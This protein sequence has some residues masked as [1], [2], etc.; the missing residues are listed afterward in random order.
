QRR[1]VRLKNRSRGRTVLDL[2]SCQPNVIARLREAATTAWYGGSAYHRPA[3]SKMGP[4]AARRHP[5]ASKCDPRWTKDMATQALREAIRA[6]RVSMA[7]D[8]T[9]PRYAW[10]QEDAA[11]YEARLTNSQ[12]GEYHAYPLE[13]K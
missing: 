13:D 3:G 10:H 12:S 1:N 4:P 8:G 9:F 11:L 5:H 2:T 6:G 7:W